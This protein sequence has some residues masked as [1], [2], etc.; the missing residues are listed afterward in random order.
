MYF[1]ASP[2]EKTKLA[3]VAVVSA[4]MANEDPAEAARELKELI[5]VPP[6]W[7][8][9]AKVPWDDRFTRE[10]LLNGISQLVGHIPSVHPLVHH[11]TNNVVKNMSANVTIAIG[12]SPAMSEC[13]DE[14]ADFASIP[15]AGVLINMGMPSPEGVKM[16]KRAGEEYNQRGRAVVFDPVAAGA[17]RLRTNACQEFLQHCAID[18][19]KGNDGEIFS[20]AQVKSSVKSHGV[21]SIGDADNAERYVAAS[22]LAKRFRTVVLMTG[23][24]D[25]IVDEHGNALIFSNGSHFLAEITGSGCSLGSVVAT[26]IATD[27][28]F[29]EQVGDTLPYGT[30]VATAAAIAL[31]TIAAE[32]AAD[33][34]TCTGPGTFVPLFID[35]LYSICKEN[36]QGNTKWLSHIKVRAYNPE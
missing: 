6:S 11:I 14:F 18:V 30:F 15:N 34:P 24:E 23:P 4:I 12:G 20:A 21:D 3:G 2:A 35:Q 27:K 32:R 36:A 1:A 31:Y 9:A 8:L 7:A 10:N 19:V 5:V 16:Y 17:T 25:L 29:L 33:F 13:V 28:S 26:L 22:T